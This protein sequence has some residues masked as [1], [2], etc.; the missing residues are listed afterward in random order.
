MVKMQV[1]SFSVMCCGQ[2]YRNQLVFNECVVV[3]IIRASMA[4]MFHGQNHQF[5]YGCHDASLKI[6]DSRQ[7]GMCCD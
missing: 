3:I 2:N 7:A 5:Q 6:T 4:Y 1:L